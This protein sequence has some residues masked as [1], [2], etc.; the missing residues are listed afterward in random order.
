MAAATTTDERDGKLT[1][2]I[3]TMLERV[4]KEKRLTVDVVLQLLGTKYATIFPAEYLSQKRQ[5][6]ADII[7]SFY[8]PENSNAEKQDKEQED[9][10]DDDDDDDDEEE[11]EGEEEEDE[12]E[13]DDDDGEDE[14]E[15]DDDDEEEEEEADGEPAEKRLR[16]EGD[17]AVA[18]RC[19]EMIVCLRRLG[20]RVRPQEAAESAESYLQECLIPLFR[21][22]GLDPERYAAAD[23]KRYLVK[24][25]LELLQSD[26]ADITLDRSARAGRGVN[27][28]AQ[29]NDNGTVNVKTSKFLDDE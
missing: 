8:N 20:H 22:K 7:Q 17:G 19:R 15:E 10:D 23:V 27:R 5:L 13:E 14:E 25:E 4:P 24:R 6:L 16:V 2:L 26:G 9:S 21:E 3:K 12:E 18:L 29:K 11:E 28:F 1:G